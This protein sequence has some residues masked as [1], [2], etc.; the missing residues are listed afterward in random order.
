MAAATTARR[1]TRPARPQLPE[2]TVGKLDEAMLLIDRLVEEHTGTLIEHGQRYRQTYRDG[3]S[4]PLTA[5][6]VAQIAAGLGTSLKDAGDQIDQAGLTNHDEPDSMEVLLAAAVGAAPAL[7]DTLKRLTALIEMTDDA[8]EQACE[9]NALDQALDDAVDGW[10]RLLVS[11]LRERAG[12]ALEHFA[13]AAGFSS[14]KGMAVVGQVIWQTMWQAMSQL[15]ALSGSSPS[16][17]SQAPTDGPGETSS[18]APPGET[19]SS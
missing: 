17:A 3:T 5:V 4:R 7:T 10:R 9:S 19:P 16:T 13:T 8:F 18:T 6:E 2:V 15:N 1:P 11:D 14:G 12:A